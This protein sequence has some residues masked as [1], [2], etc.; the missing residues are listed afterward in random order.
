MPTN[1]P[2]GIDSF[3]NPNPTDLLTNP[4][5]ATQ[6]ANEND[7]VTAIQTTLGVNP[8][9]SAA[10]VSARIAAVEAAVTGPAGGSLSGNYPNPGI[11]AGAV[12][13]NELATIPGLVG[14]AYGS[15]SQVPVI[16]VDTKGRVTAISAVPVAGGGG[17]APATSTYFVASADPALPNARVLSATDGVNLN[18]STP[19][20]GQLGLTLT[21]VTPGPYGS[22]S[23]VPVIS[24]DAYG[25]ITSIS[26][27]PI[28]GGGGGGAPPDAQYLVAAASGGLSNERVLSGVSGQIDVTFPSTSTSEIKLAEVVPG[29][30]FGSSSQVAQVQVDATGRIIGVANVPITGAGGGA[31][32]LANNLIGGTANQLLYQQAPNDTGFLPHGSLGQILKSRGS[33]NPPE[34]GAVDLSNPVSVTSTLDETN[35][36]T[37]NNTYVTGDILYASASNTLSRLPIG[38]LGRALISGATPSWDKINIDTSAP[39]SHITGTLQVANGGTGQTSAPTSGQLLIGTSAGNFAVASVTQG[40]GILV[41]PGNGTLTIAANFGTTS[42]TVAQ[43]NDSRFHNAV[44]IGATADA[45]FQLT[46]G[47]GGQV[48]SAVDPNPAS[49]TDHRLVFWDDSAGEL[50]Y[51]SLGTNLSINTGVSPAV[52]NAAS[53]VAGTVTSVGMNMGTTG[54]IVNGAVTASITSSGTFAIGGTLA[55]GNG[56]TGQTT[57]TAAFNALSPVTTKGDLIVYDGTNNVRLPVGADG[58]SLIADSTATSGVR[59]GPIDLSSST[60]VDGVLPVPNGGTGRGSFSTGALLCGDTANVLTSISTVDIGKVLVSNGTAAYPIY[61]FVKLGGSATPA[62]VTGVLSHSNGGTGLSTTPANG[63]LLIGNGSGYTLSTLTGGAGIIITNAAG[64]ITL[65]SNTNTIVRAS[66]TASITTSTTGYTADDTLSYSLSSAV[67]Y[68]F[69]F[70]IIP[71]TSAVGKN[72][73]FRVRSYYN[74][75]GTPINHTPTY[76]YYNVLFYKGTTLTAIGPFSTANNDIVASALNNSSDNR[77]VIQG[78]IRSP[79][80]SLPTAPRIRLEYR[81]S[82]TTIVVKQGS[83]LTT[84]RA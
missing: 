39:V 56:G 59:W 68:T 78:V 48:L 9:G 33:A 74:N 2:A 80:P 28:S 53:G 51:L 38:P 73:T 45:V 41:T 67:D 58:N 83:S 72:L 66:D 84:S 52:L 81:A 61:D 55:I 18:V 3:I 37:G 62:V 10:T 15:S 65:S 82:S 63:Q 64:S 49:T 22:S 21:G 1:F 23:Q 7:A 47:T 16:S 11:A 75:L 24:V 57:A 14:G 44:T 54:L 46:G 34:W 35:G 13:F 6:H 36:G 30:T 76:I 42:N 77:I 31:V 20:Q 5:H 71:S 19:G 29:G 25:R 17:G 69:E 70:H 26:T 50:R 40:N 60:R 4:P 79:A 32:E 27:A 43:G 12:G 8:Q